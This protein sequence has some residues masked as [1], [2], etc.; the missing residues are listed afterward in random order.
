VTAPLTRSGRPNNSNTRGGQAGISPFPVAEDDYS[1]ANEQKFRAQLDDI[2]APLRRQV[3]GV[4]ATASVLASVAPNSLVGNNTGV[5]SPPLQLTVAQVKALL[6]LAF[7]DISGTLGIGAGGTSQTT[8][9]AARGSSGL[10]VESGTA[11]GDAIYT[12]LATDRFVY[13]N[14]AL[15]TSRAWTLPAANTVNPGAL[16]VV[17]D[18]AFGVTVTNTIVITRAGADTING[19]TTHTLDNAG[20]FSLLWSDGASKWFARQIP[21]LGTSVGQLIRLDPTTG[22]LPAV[23]GSQ[24]T[25]ISIPPS[26]GGR[27][28]ITTGT[29]ILTSSTSAQTTVYFTPYVH[30]FAPIWNGSKFVMTDL[31]GELSQATTDATKS[32]AAVAASKNYDIFLWSDGGTMRA[33][34]GPA[35]TSDTARGTGAGTTELQ[36]VNGILNNKNAITNGPGAGAGTYVGSIRSNASSQIDFIFGTPASGGTAAVLGIWNMYNRIDFASNV[37]DNGVAYAY[38]TNT[39]RQARASAG[40]QFSLLVGQQEDGITITYNFA[41]IPASAVGA[42]CAN[43]IGLD[44][45][46]TF[47]G[48]WW[49]T[50]NQVANGHGVY[51]SCQYQMGPAELALGW[52]TIAALERGDSGSTS[53]DNQTANQLSYRWRL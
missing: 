19:A 4:A 52:H 10:N 28:T 22:K 17:A 42:Q 29:P 3:A 40:N 33:T 7:S 13:T 35:W 53:F 12:I 9:L 47:F 23:D 8:A 26:V 16:L 11:R 30:Q 46:T 50:N 15:T 24:L 6:A 39:I 44:S 20:T 25:G 38:G 49:L 1:K 41:S 14:A 31:G 2:I 37:T 48:Q 5:A 32:P 21:P 45:T 34:R 51:A 18:L 27:I 36:R 43:G